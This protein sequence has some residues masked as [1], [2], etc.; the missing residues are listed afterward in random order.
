[1]AAYLHINRDRKPKFSLRK[2]RFSFRYF[3]SGR[4]P[5][6][7]EKKKTG[8]PLFKCKYYRHRKKR[9][10]GKQ[11]MLNSTGRTIIG[12]NK[13]TL[14]AQHS[15]RFKNVKDPTK[16]IGINKE[17]AKISYWNRPVSAGINLQQRVDKLIDVTMQ[18][19]K[20]ECVVDKNDRKKNG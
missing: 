18:H 10:E 7:S 1:M 20:L 11:Y 12:K 16:F 9:S 17:I 8:F 3:D 5:R 19:G 6:F 14:D 15:Y 13:N 4:K 2:P